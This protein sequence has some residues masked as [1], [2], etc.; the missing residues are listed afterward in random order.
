MKIGIVN[1]CT[2]SLN[3]INKHIYS[4]LLKNK[5]NVEFINQY[6]NTDT[7][8]II[9][10]HHIP[11]SPIKLN[12]KQKN[13]LIQPVDGTKFH[14]HIIKNINKF[15]YII[16]PSKSSKDI[17]LKN[18]VYKPIDI[19]PNFFI[20]NESNDI[21]KNKKQSN[22]FTFYSESSMVNR[23]NIKNTL[24]YFI[25]TF[26]NKQNVN[27]VKLILKVV[28]T[29]K[30]QNELHSI[31]DKYSNDIIPEI[32]II[33]EKLSINKLNDIW[34]SVDCYI[35]LSYIEGFCI[36]ALKAISC[37]IPVIAL[38]SKLSGYID[39]LNND[40]SILINCNDTNSIDKLNLSYYDSNSICEEPNY[41]EYMKALNSIMLKQFNFNTDLNKF[42]LNNIMKKYLHFFEYVFKEEKNT[43]SLS[44]RKIKFDNICSDKLRNL[45]KIYPKINKKSYKKSLIVESRWNDTVEFCI[46]NTIQK[47]GDNWGHIIVCTNNNINEINKINK[48][49]NNKLQIINLGDFKICRNTYNNLCLDLNFW[50]KIDCE[51]V[52]I[53][54]SDTFI[55][56]Q[57]DD[58]FLNYDYIGA[59]WG[60]SLHSDEIKN[61]VGIDLYIG[62]GGL[63]L[64]SVNVMK[65]IL[66]NNDILKNIFHNSDCENLYEDLYFS[67]YV[68]KKYKI[69]PLNIAKHFSYEHIHEDN[70][71]GCHQPYLNS[72]Y[73]YNL[74]NKFLNQI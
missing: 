28:T 69:A 74:F 38:D 56:K 64:R 47:L 66:K 30:Q 33:N 50:N 71:F 42:S 63:S 52:L 17:L 46:K 8:D 2:L 3:Y 15:D 31:I 34:K 36:P 44:E 29:I 18:K 43:L 54:Q 1:N 68:T 20:D 48:E 13:I 16:V 55:F 65:D 59:P 7:F 70:T 23:K 22:K 40:N 25:E 19:I 26:K 58:I 6:Q 61:E 72:F 67:L 39:F 37:K 60:P 57:F 49:I 24:T 32:E 9:L 41:K 27:N 14:E 62:N 4:Y 10:Y 12:A 21:I 51:K 53:Y 5:Y 11:S 45:Q 35:C 73:E